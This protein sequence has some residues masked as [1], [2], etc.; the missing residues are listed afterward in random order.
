MSC[1][2]EDKGECLPPPPLTALLC[3]QVGEGII[4]IATWPLYRPSMPVAV[5]RTSVELNGENRCVTRGVSALPRPSLAV[6]SKNATYR[7]ASRKSVFISSMS[8]TAI[9]TRP[10][11]LARMAAGASSWIA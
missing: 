2:A 7:L 4:E 10:A 6:P 1:C 5:S 11:I 8:S 3:S 9:S